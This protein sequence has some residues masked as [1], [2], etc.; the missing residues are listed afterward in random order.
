E[1]LTL[2]GSGNT[3]GTGNELAN[4]IVGNAGHNLL[5]GLAGNDTLTD[6]GGGNDTLDGGTGIDSMSGGTGNDDYF[7]DNVAD[8]VAESSAT[9][10]ID[11]VES[12][13]TYTLGTNFE[14][15]SLAGT[16]N[17]DGTGNSLNNS[18]VGSTANNVLSGLAGNDTLDGS[19]GSD[20]VL[21]G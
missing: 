20:M 16:D 14:H 11:T 5:S 13:I 17:I 3:I 2:T 9:G 4:K 19:I 8:K 10:G 15:L 7:R 21:G 6:S 18:I 1:N 12:S